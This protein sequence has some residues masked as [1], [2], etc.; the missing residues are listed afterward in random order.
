MTEYGLFNDE[1]MVEGQFYSVQEAEAAIANRYDPEDE[2]SIEEV[3]EEHPEHA[4]CGCEECE[5]EEMEEE[6]E[7]EES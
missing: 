7:A 3:C 4:K 2:L 5:A 6:G 1:G